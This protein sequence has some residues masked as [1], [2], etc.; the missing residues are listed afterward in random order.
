MPQEIEIKLK[1]PHEPVREKLR[2]LQAHHTGTVHETNIFFDRDGELRKKDSGLRVRFTQNLDPSNPKPA[3]C[4]GAGQSALLT[5]KGPAATHGLRA[6]EA[7]DLSLSPPDQIIPLLQALGY[8]QILRFEKHRESWQLDLCK[9]ELDT[10]PIFGTFIE[11]EGPDEPTVQSVQQKL[12]L[13]HL[14]PELTS[15][16]KMVSEYLAKTG[17]N[18]LRLP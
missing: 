12:H 7:F 16:S 9:I 11:I 3:V 2:Q 1:S 8:H 13:A 17:Q 14:P 15:Y 18:E 5:F 6:R 10:M 4:N